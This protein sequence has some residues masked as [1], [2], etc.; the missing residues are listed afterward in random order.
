MELL[1]NRHLWKLYLCSSL[2]LLR[3]SLLSTTQKF[4]SCSN[5]PHVFVNTCRMSI[6][7]NNES[8]LFLTLFM[9]DVVNSEDCYSGFKYNFIVFIIFLWRSS[10][11]LVYP[12]TIRIHINRT[13]RVGSFSNTRFYFPI[14]RYLNFVY[15][16]HVNMPIFYLGN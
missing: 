5:N 8:I 10:S 7:R 13:Q 6:S 11:Y 15:F 4:T 12:T 14:T 16:E 3:F 9:V 1:G 2:Y